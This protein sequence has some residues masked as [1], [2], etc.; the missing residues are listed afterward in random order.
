MCETRDSTETQALIDHH[1]AERRGLDQE[2][3]DKSALLC[4]PVY[5]ADP[6]QPLILPREYVPFTADQ[7]KRQP[8]LILTH[9]SDKQAHFSRNDVLRGLAAFINDP[10]ELRAAADRALASS[11]L[12]PLFDGK[13][14]EFTT[15]DFR[16]METHLSTCTSEMA[17]S[18]GF[19]VNRKHI[20]R[21]IKHENTRLLE[22]VEANLSDEQI[23]AIH[24]ILSPNQLS[25]VIGLAGAGKSAL[26]SVARQAWEQQGYRVHG[27]ALAGKAADGLQNASGIQ[28]RTLASLEASWKSGYEPVG[29][30]DVVVIDEAG[31]VGTRQLARVADALQ[32]ADANWCWWATPTSF[33][34]FRQESRLTISVIHP[35]RHD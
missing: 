35:V 11:E 26:L 20:D 33:N 1:L 2:F 34:P 32:N 21:A 19:R 15:R 25:S 3:R 14:G 6:R 16:T 7:L 8:E 29:C 22:T 17:N 23:H 27:A 10:L 13:E 30:G 5:H 31:M 9:I 4:G 28:S 12:I 18:G 24:H